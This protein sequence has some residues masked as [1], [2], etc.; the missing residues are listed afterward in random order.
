MTSGVNFYFARLRHTETNKLKQRGIRK[1]EKEKE[2]MEEENETIQN[3]P[4]SNSPH[5]IK[6]TVYCTKYQ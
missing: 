5:F 4:A 3:T 2:K 1:E 6:E